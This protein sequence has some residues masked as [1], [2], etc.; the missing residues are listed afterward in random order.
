MTGCG[1]VM[2]ESFCNDVKCL[3]HSKEGL[4][5]GFFVDYM[6]LSAYGALKIADLIKSDLQ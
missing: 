4:D 5:K 2:K 6:H 1:K 3:D